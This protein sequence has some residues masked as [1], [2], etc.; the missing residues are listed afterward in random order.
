MDDIIKDTDN[1]YSDD[2]N[3]YEKFDK[4]G[5]REKLSFFVLKDIISA[6]MKNDTT[7]LDK[8]IDDS[9]MDH[10]KNDYKGTCYSYLCAAKDKCKSPLLAD[11][12]Q[13]I[14]ETTEAVKMECEATKNK[15]V[16][17]AADVK[18]MLKGVEDYDQFVEKLAAT[19]SEKVVDDVAGL[20]ATQGGAQAPTFS[21]LDDKIEVKSVEDAP[22]ENIDTAD[23][24]NA[25]PIEGV[26]AGATEGTEGPIGKTVNATEYY[27]TYRG[28]L[29]FAGDEVEAI[30]YL[31]ANLSTTED[32]DLHQLIAAPVTDDGYN[33]DTIYYRIKKGDEGADAVEKPQNGNQIAY[34]LIKLGYTV[35]FKAYTN[36]TEL[37]QESFW[38]PLKDKANYD[39]R[40]ITTGGYFS[41]AAAAQI[42]KVAAFKNKPA[43]GDDYLD[44]A[45]E[46]AKAMTGYIDDITDGLN[47]EKEVLDSQKTELEEQLKIYE[48]QIDKLEE[49]IKAYDTLANLVEKQAKEQT[50]LLK[51]QQKAEEEAIQKQIDAL[52]EKKDEQDEQTNL[53]EKELEVKQKLADLEKARNKRVRTYSAETGWTWGGD[54]EAVAN[55]QKD[56]DDAKKSYDKAIDDKNYNDQIKALEKQKDAVSESYE[57]QI[58]EY[59][60][61]IELWKGIE[62]EQSDI[63]AERLAEQMFGSDWREKISNKD[64]SILSKYKSYYTSYNNQLNSLTNNEIKS[65]K[66]SIKAKEDE[67]QAK[68]KQIEEWNKYKSTVEKAIKSINDANNNYASKLEGIKLTEQSSLEERSQA[69]ENFKNHYQEITDMLNELDNQDTSIRIYADLDDVRNNL[70]DFI[71]DYRD[72]I[73]AMQA[74]LGASSTG[75]GVVNSDW[76]A[77]LAE[78]AKRMRYYSSGGVA[79]YTGTAMLHGKSNASE[80]IF[81]SAQAKSLYDMVRNDEFSS[82]LAKGILET[83]SSHLNSNT[84]T[85]TNNSSVNTININGMTIKTD[86]PQQFHDQFMTEIGKYW[87]VKL[88]ESRVR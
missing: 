7:N 88:T 15:C 75:F 84:N 59:E 11:V 10:I 53:A 63:E 24:T 58:K 13:E 28:E 66:N 62:Q 6:M 8:M 20:I 30:G 81:N 55:A 34:E 47:G 51:E 32:P 40:Y 76:D 71:E 9:I 45:D 44:S 17:E 56:Y 36:V 48:E 68:E 37:D 70:A 31:K 78:A 50:D 72:G 22:E 67:I 14:E 35:L 3:C 49:T 82:N 41:A 85:N 21:N 86:N 5:F 18:E 77:K 52:K 57:S 87:N 39:F 1:R 69:F 64:M 26:D 12:I 25:E 43:S 74:A 73:E 33:K 54:K 29:Y 38:T 4:E 23:S 80:V 46:Y 60:D 19:V 42:A 16:V 79:D 27:Q 61:Y 65:L 83:L 2:P